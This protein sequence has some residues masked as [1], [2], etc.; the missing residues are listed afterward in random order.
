MPNKK[1]KILIIRLSS[2]GDVLQC[3]S[4]VGGLKNSFPKSEIHWI[5][6]SDIAPILELDP[7]IDKI[8]AFDKKTGFKGLNNT[9]KLL[10]KEKFTHIYDAHSNIRSNIIKLNLCPFWKRWIGIAPKFTMRSKERL[11]RFLLFKFRINKFPKPFRGMVSFQK[12]LSKWGITNFDFP[13][14]TW[15]FPIST[16]ENISKIIRYPLKNCICLV[17]SAAWEMKRWP[18]SH[19]KALIQQ[20]PNQ[21][22]IIIG[23]PN[24]TFCEE[25]ANSSPL[26]T[27]NLAGKTNL[28]DSCFVVKQSALTISADTGFIHAADLFSKKGMFL[29]GP[30]AFGFPTGKHIVIM[31]K[32]M[33]C[34][35]CTKDGRGKCSQKTYK[36]CLINIHPKAVAEKAFNLM[37]NTD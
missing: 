14:P 6:R 30:T 37:R 18:I 3:M 21:K 4:I 31:E 22:F 19:W 35:P 25:I 23:G 17:P 2:I 16:E 10:K 5:V 26:Q 8:W 36:E 20:M 15:N 34:R 11:K 32:E 24:D 13:T 33:T 1:H 27:I 28:V 7:R 29:V 12:P 9:I